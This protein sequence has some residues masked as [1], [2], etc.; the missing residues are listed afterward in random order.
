MG[1]NS[2]GGNEVEYRDILCSALL[3]HLFLV[4]RCVCTVVLVIDKVEPGVLVSDEYPWADWTG[5]N[6]GKA[7]ADTKKE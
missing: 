7:S 6:I 1:N 3:V 2:T 4:L 5:T